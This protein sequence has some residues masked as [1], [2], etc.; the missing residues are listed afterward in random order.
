[1]VMYSA[2]HCNAV[3][4]SPILVAS[5][6]F[7]YVVYHQFLFGCPWVAGGCFSVMCDELC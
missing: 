3:F 2:A 6:Y 7:G 1:M 5:A 4:F